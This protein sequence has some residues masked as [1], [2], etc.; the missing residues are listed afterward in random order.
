MKRNGT[1]DVLG[2]YRIFPRKQSNNLLGKKLQ[3]GV[4][5][6]TSASDVPDLMILFVACVKVPETPLI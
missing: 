3:K 2:G 5:W 6:A 1:F 4:L